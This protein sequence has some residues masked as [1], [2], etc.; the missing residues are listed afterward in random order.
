MKQ[1]GEYYLSL[2][3]AD[4]AVNTGR[5]SLEEFSNFQG[6]ITK[7][8]DQIGLLDATFLD[9]DGNLALVSDKEVYL[10]GP[11]S[12]E[13]NVYPIIDNGQQKILVIDENLAYIYQKNTFHR[14]F[15]IKS[16]VSACYFR[17]RLFLAEKNTL[18]YSQPFTVNDMTGGEFT[19]PPYL[20]DVEKLQTVNDCLMV[21]CTDGIWKVNFSAGEFKAEKFY[22]GAISKSVA[23]ANKGL[24][25]SDSKSV[26]LCDGQSVN[27]LADIPY[28]LETQG[29]HAYSRGIYALVC[30]NK[31]GK[32]YLF[33]YD[34]R[35]NESYL[36]GATGLINLGG[37]F[38]LLNTGLFQI[39]E[40]TAQAE[41]VFNKVNF[42]NLKMKKI[43]Q[44][45]LE[46][47][48]N[49]KIS[50]KGDRNTVNF[51]VSAG[52][53]VCPK[54]SGRE[55]DISVSCENARKVKAIKIFYYETGGGL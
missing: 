36:L 35:H 46:C 54:V 15:P 37:N 16:C 28:G 44:T 6:T 51:C 25:F 18:Y 23:D 48:G 42:G 12:Q 24:V 20:G 11:F 1:R 30:K 5:L 10:T 49:A 9:E 39:T 3:N 8:F 50:I 45:Y 53:T 32:E 33:V 52:E 43:C 2:E 21:F 27:K 29:N 17:N 19:L 4:F 38:V 7:M 26:Y 55:F 34:F 14:S 40:G 47:D 41:I 31:Y 13:V 22:S